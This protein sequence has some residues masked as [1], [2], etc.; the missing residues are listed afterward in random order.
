ML[1]VC[2]QQPGGGGAQGGRAVLQQP[3]SVGER[4]E[5]D[6]QDQHHEG[7]KAADNHGQDGLVPLLGVLLD[8]GLGQLLDWLEEGHHGDVQRLAHPELVP[9][10]HP[11][12]VGGAW[13]EQR[14][15]AS[16]REL[17]KVCQ[18]FAEMSG[19]LCVNPQRL[20]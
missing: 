11:D 16:E 10:L 19:L 7:H 2:L 12:R 9:D 17:I 13:R 20:I 5:E 8:L 18:N 3:P 6:H 1:G 15:E 14:S 4:Y